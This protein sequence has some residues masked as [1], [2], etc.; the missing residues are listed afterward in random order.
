MVRCKDNPEKWCTTKLGEHTSCGNSVLTVC[1][2]DDE[3]ISTVN[4]EAKVA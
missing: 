1:V 3:K 4:T 2:F